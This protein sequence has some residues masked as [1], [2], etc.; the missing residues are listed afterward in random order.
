MIVLLLVFTL[1]IGVKAI[2]GDLNDGDLIRDLAS[3]SDVV[4]HTATSD[5]LPSAEAILEG[6]KQRANRGPYG[7][8]IIETCDLT[9][10]FNLSLGLQTIYLHQSGT[11]LLGDGSSERA[12]PQIFS[13]S[14]TAAIDA[15]P[16]NAPHR[17]IDLG[18]T[19]VP[20]S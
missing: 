9:K 8:L 17:S 15:L 12:N 13:D 19:Q 5:H 18:R 1:Q 3:Q 16:A 11:A 14:D 4:F 6:I 2:R 20:F 7:H 10:T